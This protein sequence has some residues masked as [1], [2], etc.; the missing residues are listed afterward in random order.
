MKFCQNKAGIEV[1]ANY[2]FFAYLSFIGWR[3]YPQ[4]FR[5]IPKEL[6]LAAASVERIVAAM[7][8]SLFIFER[9]SLC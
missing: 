7:V 8:S 2:S 1:K 5:I 4:V 6:V 9:V 3:L